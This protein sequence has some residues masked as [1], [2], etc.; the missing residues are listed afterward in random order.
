MKKLTVLLLT[1]FSFFSCKNE[2][3]NLKDGL[4]AEIETNKGNIIVQLEFQK[5]PITVANFVT[6]AEG[7]N[8]F[9]SNNCKAKPFYNGLTFH[10]VIPNFM[11]QGGDPDGNGSGGT[12]YT[13]KDE[14]TDM[15]FDSGGVLAMAN[16]GPATNSSQFFITHVETPWLDGKHTVFGHVV[17]NGMEV[18]NKIAQDDVIKSIK[19]IRKGDAAKKF[20]AVKVFN[21][22]F[23]KEAE[24]Q[25]KQALIDAENKKVND[26]KAK[27]AQEK[28]IAEFASLK[29]TAI[30][31]PSG[32]KYKI[33]QKGS[34]KKP[35]NGATVFVH[36]AGFLENGQLFDSSIE[37]VAK[38]FGK[39]DQRRADAHQYIPLQCKAGNYPFIPGFNEG[40][41]K[42]NFGD[43]AIL[44]IPSNLAY[45]EAGAGNAVPPNANIIFEVELLE[46]M[47]KQ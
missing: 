38:E 32:L 37:N 33:I 30:K 21:D 17:E 25:K 31:T 40:L 4:Y 28:K 44:F 23:S 43:K 9:V 26:A 15:K 24:N 19:I 14:F 18:V 11:I 42:L 3:N 16:S 8:T 35:E 45:G 12:G 47:P 22:Y 41:G 39:F 6:L 46:Q 13:F 2:Q 27:V 7:K 1:L 20:D 36:Y 5:T 34:G 10:R 29:N